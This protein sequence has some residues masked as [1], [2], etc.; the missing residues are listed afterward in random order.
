MTLTGSKMKTLFAI[1]ADK[2]HRRTSG[3]YAHGCKI[4]GG[5]AG[6][7]Q[8][9]GGGAGLGSAQRAEFV[10]YGGYVCFGREHRRESGAN[11]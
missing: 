11:S 3:G 7:R 4:E 8:A 6:P 5:G 2:N 9:G 10:R 1:L